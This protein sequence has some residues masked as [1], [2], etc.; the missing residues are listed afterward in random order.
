M[1]GI[2]L[3]VAG[4]IILIIVFIAVF[5]RMSKKVKCAVG[6]QQKRR[7]S[8]NAIKPRTTQKI[9]HKACDSG[10]GSAVT[11][12]NKGSAEPLSRHDIL[13]SH[14]SVEDKNPDVVPLEPSSDDEFLA[15]E[16]AFHGISSSGSEKNFY[17]PVTT[18][19]L[20][21]P[22]PGPDTQN[23]LQAIINS[24]T[25]NLEKKNKVREENEGPLI[26]QWILIEN[27]LIFISS[28]PA[29]SL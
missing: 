19:T 26:N 3:G 23:S 22:R 9:H 27:L 5:L 16:R 24:A 14:S 1:V 12:P 18:T 13:G 28:L 7:N 2:L 21:L 10:G 8:F 20:G 15:E 11:P 17:G 6:R 29:S 4:T 25:L